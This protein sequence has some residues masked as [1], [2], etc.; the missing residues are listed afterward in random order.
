MSYELSQFIIEKTFECLPRGYVRIGDKLNLRCPVC[1]DS[2]KSASK[3]RGWVYL[4]GKGN[5]SY[6]CFNCGANMS[7]MRFLELISGGSY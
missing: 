4:S 1:G 7:G 3:R 2:K 5:P 6:H